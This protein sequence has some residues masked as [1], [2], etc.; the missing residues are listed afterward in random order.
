LEERGEVEV[1]YRSERATNWTEFGVYE[2]YFNPVRDLRV[3]HNGRRLR[4]AVREIVP[5][6]EDVFL[7]SGTLYSVHVQETPGVGDVVAYS[8]RRAYASAAYAPI[9][10]VPSVDR[11]QAY[12]IEVR[13]PRDVDVGFKVF[14]P[15]GDVEY[16]RTEED[17]LARITF[18]RLSPLEDLPAFAHNGFHAAVKLDLRRS[19]EP[20][21]PTGPD[22]FAAW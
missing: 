1:R 4:D 2:Q 19:G 18:T 17:G 13:H 10:T 20:L 9:L 11:L 21:T 15:R 16:E 6:S 3:E 7:N 5:E 12:V 8:Y 22:E 14:A